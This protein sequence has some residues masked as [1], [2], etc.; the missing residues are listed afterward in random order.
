M[1]GVKKI[2]FYCNRSGLFSIT[3]MNGIDD[4]ESGYDDVEKRRDINNAS[5]KLDN[6][7]LGYR[8]IAKCY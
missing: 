2:F 7:E 1:D 8:R 6:I 4:K 5:V 3:P